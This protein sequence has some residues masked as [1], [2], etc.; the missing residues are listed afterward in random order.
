MQ[1]QGLGAVIALL[2][3]RCC[4]TSHVGVEL[5][6]LCCSLLYLSTR[7]RRAVDCITLTIER[8]EAWYYLLCLVPMEV[9]DLSRWA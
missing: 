2:Y 6:H 4:A 7:F 5:H 8:L 3:G 9:P 1:G